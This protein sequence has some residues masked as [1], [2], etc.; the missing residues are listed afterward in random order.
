MNL[1]FFYLVVLQHFFP[2]A[3]YLNIFRKEII[4]LIQIMSFSKIVNLAKI[5]DKFRSFILML[6]KSIVE[7]I[8]FMLGYVVCIFMFALGY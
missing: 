4:V 5:F 6:V 3:K 2:D 7:S 1:F 8:H